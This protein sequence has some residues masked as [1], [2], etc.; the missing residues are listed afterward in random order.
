MSRLP[1]EFRFWPKLVQRGVIAIRGVYRDGAALS[2]TP[3]STGA[4]AEPLPPLISFRRPPSPIRNP[5]RR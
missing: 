2:F 5:L 4:L 3:L 1:P